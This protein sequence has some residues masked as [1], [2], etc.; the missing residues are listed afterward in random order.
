MLNRPRGRS[1]NAGEPFDAAL[2]RGELPAMGASRSAGPGPIVEAVLEEVPHAYGADSLTGEEGTAKVKEEPA[3][4]EHG[5]EPSHA[6][7]AAHSEPDQEQEQGSDPEAAIRLQ[8]LKEEEEEE[9]EGLDAEKLALQDSNDEDDHES[10]SAPFLQGI[11][12]QAKR[13]AGSFVWRQTQ[14]FTLSGS[15]R[16]EAAR[17]RDRC[18]VACQEL[19][20]LA[21]VPR[22]ARISDDRLSYPRSEYKNKRFVAA[23]R[24]GELQLPNAAA[25]SNCKS[26]ARDVRA[27]FR[28]VRAFLEKFEAAQLDSSDED[29]ITEFEEP[30]DNSGKG[31]DE[32]EEEV[33]T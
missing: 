24:R 7:D 26:G 17:I 3:L 13:F 23:I 11:F 21:G 22:K 25:A 33:Y 4:S 8:E 5:D 6:D 30:E 16:E 19:D 28:V 20:L 15:T 1:E 9:D 27:N 32:D 2:Q 31:V 10:G 29:A 18:I 12:R 14:V